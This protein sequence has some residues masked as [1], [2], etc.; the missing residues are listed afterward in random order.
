MSN[1]TVRVWDPVVRLFHW[2]LVAA[3]AVVWLSSEGWDDLHV[4][5]GYT[6]G[7]L[8]ALRLVWGLIG[9][10]YARFAQFLRGPAAVI[11]YLRDMLAGRERRYLGHNPAGAA[12]VVALLVTLAGT[13]WTGWLL[14]APTRVAALPEMPQ[15]V[16]PARAGEGEGGIVGDVHEVLANLLL[17]LIALHVGGI[18]LASWRHH[19]NL[20][21]AMVSGD[22]R[23]PEPGDIA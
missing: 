5:S 22:K 21:R 10:R 18:A 16:S 11:A 15:I 13:V 4:V 2:G 3:V 17:W 14:D 9:G 1:E 20:A 6:V 19:E 7:A 23:A 8:V 12:M